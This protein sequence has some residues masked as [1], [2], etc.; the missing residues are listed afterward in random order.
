MERRWSGPGAP[1][2]DAY[3]PDRGRHCPR[4]VDARRNTGA[5]R[6]D[7]DVSGRRVLRCRHADLCRGAALRRCTSDGHT[8]RRALDRRRH[9]SLDRSTPRARHRP[10][11]PTRAPAH[12]QPLDLVTTPTR[13]ALCATTWVRIYDTIDAARTP[14]QQATLA[15]RLEKLVHAP[16]HCGSLPGASSSSSTSPTAPAEAKRSNQNERLCRAAALGGASPRPRSPR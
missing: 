2:A 3:L 8:I 15:E 11:R 12:Q 13:V 16:D 1:S 4:R 9:P 6:P 5:G 10:F 7:A 14:A